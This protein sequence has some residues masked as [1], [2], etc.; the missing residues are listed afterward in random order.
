MAAACHRVPLTA[1]GARGTAVTGKADAFIVVVA[2]FPRVFVR[3][4]E[5]GNT[6]KHGTEQ[7]GF[8][9]S[10][11]RMYLR[12]FHT[13]VERE[14]RVQFIVAPRH[15]V[16]PRFP[17]KSFVVDGARGT[18]T[19][20]YNDAVSSHAVGTGAHYQVSSVQLPVS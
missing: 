8:G 16:P 10:S 7:Q 1:Y 5:S 18:Q 4:C 12:V 17:E 19:L 15:R 2:K 13:T 3:L 9:S 14:I 11:R 6:S 20:I